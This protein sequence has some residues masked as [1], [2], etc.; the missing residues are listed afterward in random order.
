MSFRYFAFSSAPWTV[1]SH[2]LER[3]KTKSHFTVLEFGVGFEDPNWCA[4]SHALYV[5]SGLLDIILD[6][7]EV[8]LAPGDACHLEPGTRHRVRNPGEQPVCLFV[9]SDVSFEPEA[10]TARAGT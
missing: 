3:K 10:S 9:V 4:R 6:D 7:R 8:R 1:G 5:I 2:S